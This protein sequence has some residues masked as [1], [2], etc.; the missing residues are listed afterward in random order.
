MTVDRGSSACT[1]KPRSTEHAHV[2]Q[3]SQI[4]NLKCRHILS[5]CKGGTY[6]SLSP[7][8]QG[9]ERWSFNA[10]GLIDH[11]VLPADHGNRY[12]VSSCFRSTD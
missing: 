10:H 5:A 1:S 6:D 4:T 12:L 9:W 7:A 2:T 8:D 3:D 11:E